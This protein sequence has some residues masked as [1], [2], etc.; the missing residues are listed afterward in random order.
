GSECSG[1]SCPRRSGTSSLQTQH[2]LPDAVRSRRPRASDGGEPA[3]LQDPERGEVVLRHVRGERTLIHDVDELPQGFRR[4]PAAPE[5]PPQPVADE[6]VAVVD[7]AEDVARDV[8]VD[9][10]RPLDPCLV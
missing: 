4:D 1:T 9:D 5:L 6:T 7:P 2:D 10:D 3:L 8:S